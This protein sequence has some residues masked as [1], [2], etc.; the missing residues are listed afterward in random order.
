MPLHDLIP[1]LIGWAVAIASPGP[2]TL[3]ITG[4]ALAGGRA[5]GLAVAMGVVTGS[6]VW[7]LIA[8]LG[9]GAVMMGHAWMIEALRYGGAAYLIWLAWKSARSALR[10]GAAING[11]APV[12]SLRRAWARG[13]LIHLT[14]PKAALF[15]GAMFAVVIPVGSPPAVLWQV[16]LS[17]LA[18]SVATFTLMALAFSS[19][20]VAWAWLRARRAFDAAFAL[21]FGLAALR[22][23]TARLTLA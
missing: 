17:C 18:V 9:L 20:P 12:E 5:R 6:A 13:A 21:M 3:A 2:A 7:A 1:I 4:T 14:N 16:G 10:S 19:R 22:V 23:L 15:W 8:G 11:V